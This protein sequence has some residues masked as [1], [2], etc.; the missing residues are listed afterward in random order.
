MFLK[1][2]R[3]GFDAGG[4]QV[5]SGR[6][7]MLLMPDWMDPDTPEE[8]RDFKRDDY[9]TKTRAIVRFV[10]MRQLGNFMMGTARVLGH[11]LSVSGAY[12]GDGLTMRVPWKVYQVGVPVPAD[13][14]LA[15]SNG[16]GHNGAGSEG[17]AM[18]EF[19]LSID[20][21]R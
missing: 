21:A 7:L 9:L 4:G 6:F 5:A 18:R 2:K 17:G 1:L 14:M 20:T 8:F 16:G 12:G 15:W 3:S 19:G 13:L 10:S 11:K